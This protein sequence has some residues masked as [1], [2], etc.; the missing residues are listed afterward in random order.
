MM[1][2]ILFMFSLVIVQGASEYLADIRDDH[3]FRVSGTMLIEKF[4]SIGDSIISL[5]QAISGGEDWGAYL[6]AISP[7]GPL[8]SYL[9]I[10]FIGFCQI[11]LLNILTGIF[12]E[13]ALQKAQPT[14]EQ[15]ALEKHEEETALNK[16]LQRLIDAYDP[17][18]D[19]RVPV[20]EFFLGVIGSPLHV[21][22]DSM[23]VSVQELKEFVRLISA[24]KKGGPNDGTISVKTLVNGC[25]MVR[26]SARNLDM[27]R[28]LVGLKSI[29][30]KQDSIL[31]IL[32]DQA[33]LTDEERRRRS[34]L[35][36]A[37]RSYCDS[38]RS[39]R[40]EGQ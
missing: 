32:N 29:R 16:H 21:Y 13:N 18:G 40:S 6:K 25:H 30:R 4:G 27:Q 1:V 31:G 19:G 34:T 36:E 35:V 11:S 9:F 14:K 20:E 8:Y 39:E 38:P 37:C 22:L 26:G 33:G 2:L 5:Y 3:D 12:V 28:V 15:I 24:G 17:D 23:D 7:I 10:C